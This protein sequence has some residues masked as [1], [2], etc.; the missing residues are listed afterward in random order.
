MICGAVGVAKVARDIS[1]WAGV[2]A[3]PQ[4]FQMAF[5]DF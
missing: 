3:A 2:D 5:S 4:H 1:I